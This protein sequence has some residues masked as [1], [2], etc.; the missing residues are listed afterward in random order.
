MSMKQDN[1]R[2]TCCTTTPIRST[3]RTMGRNLHRSYRTT[4]SVTRERCNS[5]YRGPVLQDDPTHCHSDIPYVKRASG[6][7]SGS[8]MEATWS[9]QKDCQ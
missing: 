9:T 1:S 3:E 2:M 4:T 6:D 8:N 5:S 7:L